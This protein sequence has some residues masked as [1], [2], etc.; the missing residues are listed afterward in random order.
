MLFILHYSYHCELQA[1]RFFCRKNQCVRSRTFF[2]PKLWKGVVLSSLKTMGRNGG[3]LLSCPALRRSIHCLEQLGEMQPASTATTTATAERKPPGTLL[4]L[5]SSPGLWQQPLLLLQVIWGGPGDTSPLLVKPFPL[6]YNL[7]TIMV[8]FIA[9]SS[10][11]RDSI[12]SHSI[13]PFAVKN[14]EL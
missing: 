7:F 12:T 10:V 14:A 2:L 4:Q 11:N 3:T 6:L 8:V 9:R 13:F 5:Q 1:N